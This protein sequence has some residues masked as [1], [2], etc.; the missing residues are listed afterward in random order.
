M[1]DRYDQDVDKQKQFL[2]ENHGNW[3]DPSKEYA[4]LFEK[5]FDL[6]RQ[7]RM[8]VEREVADK[9]PSIGYL[10][11]TSLVGQNYFNT[12]FT[13]NFD[14]LLNEAF[15]LYSKRR[16]IICA[17]DSSINSVTITSKRPK[18]IKLHGDY[19]FDDLKSTKDE[20]ESLQQNM[21]AK[22]AEFA[23]DYGLVVVGYGGGDRS[24]MDVLSAL[25]K[26]EDYF[27]HGIYWCIRKG[28]QPD[29]GLK[30]LLWRERVYWVEID[31]FDELFA[32]LYSR[33]NDGDVLPIQ[34]L[35]LTHRP[36][37]VI[38]HLLASSTAFPTTTDVL[39]K[40]R[41]RL[42]RQSRRSTLANLIARPDEERPL[43][44][45][46]DNASED[47]LVAMTEIQN[48]IAATKYDLAA[49]KCRDALA[50][51]PR[52]SF[53]HNLLRMQVHALKLGGQHGEALTKV[54]ELIRMKPKSTFP[55]LLRAQ[56]CDLPDEKLLAIDQAIS[57]NQYS[58][59]AHLARAR[60]FMGRK[61]RLYGQARAEAIKSAADAL[62]TSLR[63]NHSSRNIAWLLKARL[64][65]GERIT[66]N[67]A[68]AALAASRE[69]LAK[70]NPLA[71]Y[72]LMIR[73][74]TL[75]DDPTAPEV[76][77]LIADIEQAREQYGAD[78]DYDFDHLILLA[79]A[80]GK[81]LSRMDTRI[82]E[83]RRK[84][85]LTSH[86]DSTLFVANHLR[87]A[88]ADDS[89]AIQLLQAYLQQQDFDIGVTKALLDIHIDLKQVAEC[90][91]L[92]EKWS[93]RLS[94]I[95]R[96]KWK[97]SILELKQRYD[98]ALVQYQQL[99]K[100]TK[101]S[102]ATHRSY[103]L[104]RQNKPKECESF[105]REFL[106]QISFSC[107]AETEVVNYEFAR[108]LN[109]DSPDKA[110]LTQI[111]SRN[112]SPAIRAAAM[113][114]LNNRTGAVTELRKMLTQ[115]KTFRFSIQQW[116]ILESLRSE[117]EL[118]RL[119]SS[120]ATAPVLRTAA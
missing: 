69:E 94:T 78:D 107:E 118:V 56:V 61:K 4:S 35:T 50:D 84:G 105:L 112:T 108:K 20:T 11:L 30:K 115:D 95:D 43:S 97:A 100:L 6:P 51:G 10:Y 47:E 7:R 60:H 96:I 22:F 48:L 72:G 29:E 9:I 67:G 80:A 45:G 55:Y 19:L 36:A 28:S 87:A 64:L 98:D 44:S 117:P 86:S 77:Q 62:D 18:V 49:Q 23:K 75:G 116:P 1:V 93:P 110:R 81:Q 25:L 24:I 15:Y 39:A 27:K 3:Y 66:G 59:D 34:E 79:L 68:K 70:I 17:H 12:V 65:W 88:Y 5:K 109:K 2:K 53:Q 111:L 38:A 8:F 52:L 73:Q 57:V 16:P 92:V 40:A 91:A 119:M 106:S 85:A 120:I 76:D 113:L 89:Q 102:Y 63:L 71:W 90:E 82:E 26:N 99:E 14:D 46:D 103:I 13:T 41:E 31:G 83:L 114:L 101:S 42:H 33:F 104:L 58:E 74:E 21:R 32:A 54:D 37:E